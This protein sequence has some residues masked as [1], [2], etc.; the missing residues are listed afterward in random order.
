V[1]FLSGIPDFFRDKNDQAVT[2]AISRP[3]ILAVLVDFIVV[4]L[5]LIFSGLLVAYIGA[6]ITGE[7]WLDSL[8]EPM[9]ISYVAVGFITLFLSEQSTKQ[10]VRLFNRY[11]PYLL[12]VIAVFQSISSSIKSFQFGLTHGRYFV[13]LFGL[14]AIS[15]VIIYGF[16]KS[17]SRY[18][19]LILIAL[20]TVSILPFIDSVSIGTASQ[21]RQ[22]EEIVQPEDVLDNGRIRTEVS[23][24]HEERI[25]LSYSFNYL[26]NINELER[27]DWLPERFDYYNNFQTVFGFDP[28]Y[29]ANHNSENGEWSPVESEYA[30]V[31]LDNE[32]PVTFSLAGMDDMVYFSVYQS[33]GFNEETR[34]DLNQENAELIIQHDDEMFSLEL[35]ENDEVIMVFDL[36]FLQEDIYD[37]QGMSQSRP[38][39]DLTFVEENEEVVITLIVNRFETDRNAFYGGDFTVLLDYK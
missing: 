4:P 13:L 8:I 27:L 1:Y 39:E 5:I 29:F 16:F 36:S 15:G 33:E 9:L 22:I 14:F 25:Q 19:P 31:E 21:I 24:S 18:I 34:I 3:K 7:F 23:F 10:W 17:A 26:S 6:N 11:F 28:Y 20:G 38:L 2:E 37:L 32:Q 30:Y 12:L 35:Q